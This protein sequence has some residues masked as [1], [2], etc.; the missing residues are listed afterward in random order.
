MS[1]GWSPGEAGLGEGKTSGRRTGQQGRRRPTATRRGTAELRVSD[2]QFT[3]T[4][5]LKCNQGRGQ[6]PH[7][8]F[9]TVTGPGLGKRHSLINREGGRRRRD[10]CRGQ[11]KE[12][13]DFR[14]PPLLCPPPPAPTPT[15]PAP[16]QQTLH[17]AGRE[18]LRLAQVC[19]S[20]ALTPASNLT[21]WG[22]F[23][24]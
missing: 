24:L 13:W 9:Q 22:L 16:S 14:A 1:Q 21:S 19:H 4:Q 10:A 17:R 7:R 11:R 3:R 20:P 18:P 6:T 15:D 2:E 23:C 8:V 12:G 5:L